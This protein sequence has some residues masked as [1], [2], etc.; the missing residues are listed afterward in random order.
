MSQIPEGMVGKLRAV[1]AS[2]QSL[3][4]EDALGLDTDATTI[5][6]SG[7]ALAANPVMVAG[8]LRFGEAA[9]RILDGDAGRAVVHATSGA[10]L[11]QNMVSVL[12]SGKAN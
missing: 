5:N 1:C 7:G 6:P 9:Q 12:E 3:I 11:Q 10:C 8:L 2:V 4:V